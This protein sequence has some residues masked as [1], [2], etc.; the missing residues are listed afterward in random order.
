V[1]VFSGAQLSG[2]AGGSQPI[3]YMGLHG[4]RDNVLNISSGRSLRDTFVRNN[5]C[6]AQNPPEPGNGSLTHIVTAY[7]GCR[8]G[9][10]VVWAAFDNGHMP[11]PVDGTT[12]ESGITTWTKGEVWKFF[13]QFDGTTSPSPSPSPT[14]GTGTALKG[15]GSGRCLDVT[16]VSQSNGAQA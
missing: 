8:S 12:A 4:I 15:A 7:S 9:Y 5:G 16:G 14:P 10:P 11:G 6:T 1:A 13:S 2:C 3:A